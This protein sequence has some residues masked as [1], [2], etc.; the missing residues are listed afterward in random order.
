MNAAL[1]QWQDCTH[2]KLLLDFS[3]CSLPG[4]ASVQQDL[5]HGLT[6]LHPSYLWVW[7]TNACTRQFPLCLGGANSQIIA[8]PCLGPPGGR[9]RKRIFLYLQC[10]SLCRNTPCA[11]TQDFL[12]A[13]A[14]YACSAIICPYSSRTDSFLAWVLGRLILSH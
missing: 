14:I 5:S 6:C 7:N 9:G 11:R 12:P 13:S 3:Q 2:Q 10:N 4:L 1:E 8:A